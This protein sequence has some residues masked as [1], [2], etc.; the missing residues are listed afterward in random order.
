MGNVDSR[1]TIKYQNFPTQ[2]NYELDERGESIGNEP[3]QERRCSHNVVNSLIPLLVIVLFLVLILLACLAGLYS[4]ISVNSHKKSLNIAIKSF[5]PYFDDQYVCVSHHL[6]PKD[7]YYVTKFETL[8]RNA[9]A[10]HMLLYACEE[11]A[12]EHD[13][14]WSCGD[15]VD[16]EDMHDLKAAT[17]LPKGPLCGNGDLEIIFAEAMQAGSYSLPEGVS[18]ELG[19][20]S[21]FNYLTLQIHY[22]SVDKFAKNLSLSDDSG[23]KLHLADKP[24]KNKAHVMVLGRDSGNIPEHKL[25]NLDTLCTFGSPNE[26]VS[27]KPFAFRTHAHALGKLISGYVINPGNSSDWKL[28]ARKSPQLRQTFYP[29]LGDGITIRSMDQIAVRCSYRNPTNHTVHIGATKADEMCNLY[30]MYFTESGSEMGYQCQ[31]NWKPF[32]S[33][34]ELQPILYESSHLTNSELEEVKK[35]QKQH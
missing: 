24:T 25:T 27:L 23:L 31:D 12:F 9:A 15:M 5:R 33:V 10:H 34:G 29:V 6:D 20:G 22:A 28:I 4:Y 26:D 3:K 19:H 1:S 13:K 11:P 8:D 18:F 2:E 35:E 14:I 7:S 32:Y 30:I 17:K 16:H 21:K